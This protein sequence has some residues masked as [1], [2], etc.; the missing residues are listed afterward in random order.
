MSVKQH[1]IPFD[2]MSVRAILRG[3]KTATRRPVWPQPEP[4][5]VEVPEEGFVNM[6]DDGTL[7]GRDR[8][9]AGEDEFS[10]QASGPTGR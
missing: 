6:M 5:E 2:G 8:F 4:G 3:Q 1:P 10:V 9:L 7:V